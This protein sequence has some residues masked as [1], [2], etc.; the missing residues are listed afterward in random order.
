MVTDRLDDG[1]PRRVSL[2]LALELRS[3]RLRPEDALAFQPHGRHRDA[4]MT[5]DQSLDLRQEEEVN[6]SFGSHPPDLSTE[7]LTSSIR[8]RCNGVVSPEED[9]AHPAFL[10]FGNDPFLVA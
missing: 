8:C 6:F 3:P 4:G 1:Q 2:E 9:V 7:C 5:A 10:E